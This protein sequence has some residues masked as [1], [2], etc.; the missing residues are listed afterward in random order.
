MNV[1]DRHEHFLQ[2]RYKHVLEQKRSLNDK[3]F[4]LLSVYQSIFALASGGLAYSFMNDFKDHPERKFQ[5]VQALV[6]AVCG[7]GLFTIMLLACGLVAWL[8]YRREQLK[9]ER[10][11]FSVSLV[12]VKFSDVLKWYETYIILAVAVSVGGFVLFALST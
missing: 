2:E 5:A 6:L 10:E 7:S 9:I 8:S 4:L 12:D 11:I 1:S 3:T